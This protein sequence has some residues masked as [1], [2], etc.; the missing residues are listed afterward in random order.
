MPPKNKLIKSLLMKG[1]SE[2]SATTFA[3]QIINTILFGKTI[4]MYGFPQMYYIMLQL[5]NANLFEYNLYMLDNEINDLINLINTNPEEAE[6]ST[7][8]KY[9]LSIELQ[10]KNILEDGEK[11]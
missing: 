2:S 7:Y 3:N 4:V 11:Y 10:S 5:D 8:E 1:K 9:K 6:V